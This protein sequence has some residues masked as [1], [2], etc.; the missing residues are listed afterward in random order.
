MSGVL[1]STSAL[2]A[3]L[4]PEGHQG[5]VYGADSSAVAMANAVG[6]M[7]G[8]TMAAGLGLRAPFLLAA[9]MFA[10][11]TILAWVLV[12]SKEKGTRPTPSH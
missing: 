11:A 5:A 4:A 2:L 1:A 9:A 12:P 6:A 10:A 3:N 7:L 8:A